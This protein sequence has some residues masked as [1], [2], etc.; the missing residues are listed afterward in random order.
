[1]AYA[2]RI[3]P[4]N[5]FNSPWTTDL[6]IRIQQDLPMWREHSLQ[7]FLDIENAL[8]L[9]SDSN[10]LSRYSD[11]GDIEEGVRVM[12]LESPPTPGVFVVEDV[13]FEGTDLDVDDSVYRI[14][15]GIR[16]NF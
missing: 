1:S 4:K 3:A 6:D 5:G 8:N 9:F 15:L 12:Q 13:F 10:N 11:T 16:Y 14:Q 7:V 2:G